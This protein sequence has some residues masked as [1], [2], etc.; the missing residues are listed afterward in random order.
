[1][2]GC[3]IFRGWTGVAPVLCQ[4]ISSKCK[5]KQYPKLE[6]PNDSYIGEQQPEVDVS[7]SADVK[8]L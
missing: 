5:G 8:E 1:M 7:S 3:L 6:A 4:E 2:C